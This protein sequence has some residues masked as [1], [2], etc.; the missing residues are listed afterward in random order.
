[1]NSP[2]TSSSTLSSSPYL[3]A[4]FSISNPTARHVFERGTYLLYA[5]FWVIPRRLNF[6]CQRFGTL[7]LFHL[8]RRVGAC[9][10]IQDTAKVLNQG[11]TSCDLL[12]KLQPY[13][14]RWPE[15]DVSHTKPDTSAPSDTLHCASYHSASCRDVSCYLIIT[16]LNNTFSN[17]P[18][19]RQ[20]KWEDLHKKLVYK[21]RLYRSWPILNY[22]P[23]FTKKSH[24][25]FREFDQ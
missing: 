6:I 19:I 21:I 3:Q 25:N 1:M 15:Q 8:H 4:V 17:V 18:H 24:K 20:L 9:R 22:Y 13:L 7:C 16:L 14:L 10:I 2:S 23:G 12:I 11:P 5:F